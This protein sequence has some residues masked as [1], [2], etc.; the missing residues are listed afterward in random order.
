MK[1]KKTVVELFLSN[2][3][4]R[5]W[6]KKSLVCRPCHKFSYQFEPIYC[7]FRYNS[8]RLVL[9]SYQLFPNSYQF[10]DFLS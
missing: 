3:P 8:R 9:F 4:S 2:F 10:L 1:L 5:L 6:H 7:H